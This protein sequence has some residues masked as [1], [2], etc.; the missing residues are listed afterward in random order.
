MSLII[1]NITK[2]FNGSLKDTLSEINF[3]IKDGEFLSIIGPSGCGKSTLL[4]IIAGLEKP[5]SGEIIL[6]GKKIEKP[7]ADRVVMFQ[8]AA[9]YPW[10]DVIQNV[11]FGLDIAGISKEEQE[12]KALYY[13]KMVQLSD[14]KN[15]RIHELSGGMKQRVSLARALALESKILLMD[16]PFSALD[17]QTK[18]MLRDEIQNIWIQTKK[19]ILLITH[20]VEEALF[21]SDRII[22]LGDNPGQIKKI[23]NVNI[24]RPRHIENKDFIEIRADILSQ[25]RKEV[26]KVAQKEY[27]KIK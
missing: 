10:L 13:L 7:G 14:F 12:K 6:D 15:Y 27:D 19:T 22:M 5:T 21:F 23:Y 24:E 18:N 3:E 2:R 1:K 25:I 20:S 9:L 16:E 4:N 17:K 26:E 8:E 11:K